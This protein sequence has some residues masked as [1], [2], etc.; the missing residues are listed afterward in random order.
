MARGSH[1]RA[2][3][4][5]ITAV[6]CLDRAADG[7]AA[8]D[9][10]IGQSLPKRE[11]EILLVGDAANVA[12]GPASLPAGAVN[13]RRIE[14]SAE[15]ASARAL[16][17]TAARAPLV[18]FLDRHA[19]AEPGWLASFCRTFSQ[20]GEAAQVVGGRVR[21]RWTTARP[22]WLDD[23]LLPDLSLV[24]LGDEARF[25]R[26]GERLAA[27][28]LACRKP[29]AG[30]G[31]VH[32]AGRN[33]AA[34]EGSE[35]LL[36]G[37]AAPGGG[38]VYDPHAAAEFVVPADWLS[39]QW[40]RRKA[41]WQAVADFSRAAPAAAD[42]AERWQAV[43]DFFFECPPSERTIRGLILRQDD[44]RRFRQQIAAIYDSTYCL[45]AGL[46]EDAYD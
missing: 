13:L 17:L 20:F 8:I 35:L 9:S 37:I 25:L 31:D 14:G 4:L 26:P 22:D 16:A 21:P 5:R 27:V 3:E 18:A 42:V 40:F 43:K 1:Q 34:A 7:A 23:E 44:P 19:V 10:L 46:G 30:K 15:P 38:Q 24:E 12:G 33:G 45:L 6:I 2:T 41:A 36:D 32:P 29:A 39:Q 28:N 11:Y